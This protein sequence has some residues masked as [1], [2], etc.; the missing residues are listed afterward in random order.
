MSQPVASVR[1]PALAHAEPTYVAPGLVRLDADGAPHLVGG[2]CRNCGVHSFPKAGICSA[3]LSEEIETVDL[4]REGRLY[5]YSVVH[6]A[7]RGWRV[8]Y[9]LGYVDLPGD[10]RVL[11]H[12]DA[13]PSRLRI[14]MPVRLGVGE[15]GA[16]ASGRTLVTY[17]FSPI[18]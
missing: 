4:A 11:A 13:E 3:C 5:S 1:D 12:L 2:R 8:P 9:A 16:D 6:Q 17:T 7:P 10:I 18:E 15:V 14:D